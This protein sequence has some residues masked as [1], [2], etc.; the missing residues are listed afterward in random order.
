MASILKV[1]ITTDVSS[2]VL[3][4]EAGE[5]VKEAIKQIVPVIIDSVKKES[6]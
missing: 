5:L 4:K 3:N 6:K 1:T 2:D